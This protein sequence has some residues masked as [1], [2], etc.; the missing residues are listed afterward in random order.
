MGAAEPSGSSSG[1][2]AVEDGRGRF[3]GGERKARI[4]EPHERREFRKAS[5]EAETARRRASGREVTRSDEGG[6]EKIRDL[7]DDFP[8]LVAAREVAEERISSAEEEAAA[9]ERSVFSI[10]V[11]PIGWRRRVKQRGGITRVLNQVANFNP[12]IK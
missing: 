2:W 1:F 5:R 7:R 9:E 4:G 8:G 10:K 6:R 12:L 3:R 11:R